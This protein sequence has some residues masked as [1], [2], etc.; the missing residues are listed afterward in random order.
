[1][2]GSD[3][4]ATQKKEYKRLQMAMIELRMVAAAACSRNGF[5]ITGSGHGFVDSIQH[6]HFYVPL[7]PLNLMYAAMQSSLS[8]Q[9]S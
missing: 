7:F 5:P 9:G 6:F 8:I 3:R 1:M 4:I 2:R